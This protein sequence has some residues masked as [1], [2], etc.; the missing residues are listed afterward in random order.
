MKEFLDFEATLGTSIKVHIF[1]EGHKILQNLHLTFV[2]CSA[3]QKQ[4][5]DFAKFC[6]LLRI[7]ELYKWKSFDNQSMMEKSLFTVV[8]ASN[9]TFA[10]H[11]TTKKHELIHTGEIS[12]ACM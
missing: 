10:Y 5:E 2:I 9:E 1:W 3:S 12:C 4:G 7:Y 11:V 6:G 8:F